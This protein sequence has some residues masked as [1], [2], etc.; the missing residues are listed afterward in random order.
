MKFHLSRNSTLNTL[1]SR[2]SD[3]GDP[4]DL[5]P[6]YYVHTS[7]GRKTSY[8]YKIAPDAAGKF[9]GRKDLSEEE[10][11]DQEEIARI[12]WHRHISSTLV[13]NGRRVDFN[14]YMPSKGVLQLTRS[15]KG[16]DGHTYE[17]HTGYTTPYL[18]RLDENSKPS[19]RIVDFQQ[20]NKFTGVKHAYLEIH[21]EGEH[22]LHQQ[23]R[24]IKFS[25]R[26]A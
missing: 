22:M 4:E 1:L 13:Y 18:V 15:F 24:T 5:A 14:D 8:I 17:W 6:M 10:L 26:Q 21:P 16:P 11:K 25:L 23:F 9:K 19:A 3:S 7:S 20:D 2:V 12:H